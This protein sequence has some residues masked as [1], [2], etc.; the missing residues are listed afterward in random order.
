VNAVLHGRSLMPLRLKSSHLALLYFIKEKKIV[1]EICQHFQQKHNPFD[2]HNKKSSIWT[3]LLNRLNNNQHN[4]H[5]NRKSIEYLQFKLAIQKKQHPLYNLLYYLYLEFFEIKRGRNILQVHKIEDFQLLQNSIQMTPIYAISIAEYIKDFPPAQRISYLQNSIKNNAIPL[6]HRFL[7]IKNFSDNHFHL[8]GGNNFT[9]RLHKMLQTPHNVSYKDI[10]DNYKLY[11][12]KKIKERKFI[13][14]ATS[15]LEQIIIGQIIENSKNQNRKVNFDLF[16]SFAKAMQEN[17]FTR[18][19]YLF[20]EYQKSSSLYSIRPQSNQH[21]FNQLKTENYHSQLIYLIV[22]H[23]LKHEIHKADIILWILLGDILKGEHHPRLKDF[24]FIYL[25]LRNILHTFIIQEQ[26]QG[27]LEYFSSYSRSSMRRDKKSYELNDTFSSILDK[28][29]TFYIEGRMI[30]HPT[31]QA[32]ADDIL[33][34]FKAFIKSSLEIEHSKNKIKFM[35]HYRKM[36]EKSNKTDKFYSSLVPPRY[37]MY[38][39]KIFQES[40]VFLDFLS[41]PH[42]KEYKVYLSVKEYPESFLKKFAKEN[43][44]IV[45]INRTENHIIVDLHHLISG[46]DA[47]SLEYNTPPEVFAPVYNYIKQSNELLHKSFQFSFHTGE[48]TEDITSSLRRILET[49][50][51]LNLKK[52]DRLGHALSLGFNYNRNDLDLETLLITQESALDN[53]IFLY[54]LFYSLYFKADREQYLVIFEQKI[55]LLGSKIY[56]S[57]YTINQHINGWILRRNSPIVIK[58]LLDNNLKFFKDDKK[59]YKASA[60]FLQQANINLFHQTKHLYKYKLFFKY[61]AQDIFKLSMKQETF[62]TQRYHSARNDKKAW[63]LLLKYHF[64]AKVRKKGAKQ[65]E[66]SPYNPQIIEIAQDLIMEHIIAKNDIIIEVMP[67]S[68]LLN[69][70]INSYTQHP[71]FR[72]KPVNNSLKEYNNHNI[73]TTPLKIIINTDNPGFQATSYL[74]ELFLINEAGIKLG[75]N[76]KDIENYISEIVEL[77]N[78]IFT[79]TASQE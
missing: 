4:H 78:M 5:S 10:P 72:F 32:I 2:F 17:N 70:Q 6:P 49:I 42:Y 59:F 36:Q 69:S 64:S 47:A 9:Y 33:K 61:A 66:E 22:Q 57:N 74:N 43:H 51:F 7:A 15:I 52:G 53:A 30:F 13:V 58:K 62:C 79:G 54:F 29:Y 18:L 39:K 50:V 24:I 37:E 71:L 75:Y 8:G 27:G 45:K 55:L 16:N 48:D 35:F 34:W 21:F 73:R 1:D 11:A 40:Q 56:N 3:I 65:V 19:E 46:I 41:N 23:N 67:T 60:K 68:N 20:K 76:H 44:A 31:Q 26:N 38:Q 63:E 14:Y 25:S 77:G 12:F 28:N